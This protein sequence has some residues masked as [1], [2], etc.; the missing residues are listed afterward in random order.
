MS[1]LRKA[2]LSRLTVAKMPFFWVDGSLKGESV[3][4]C[5]SHEALE[6]RGPVLIER[7]RS[8][9]TWGSILGPLIL[10]APMY[11]CMICFVL[12]LLSTWGFAFITVPK[13]EACEGPMLSSEP[14]I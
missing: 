11:S 13:W 6:I 7:A 12:E 14:C 1:I 8:S 2:S 4:K 5:T 9:T 3:K 10:E